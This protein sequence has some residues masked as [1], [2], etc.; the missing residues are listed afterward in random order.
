MGT[1]A[2]APQRCL[3][4]SEVGSAERADRDAFAKQLDAQVA[5]SG[6]QNPIVRKALGQVYLEKREFA[7]AIDQLKQAAE[8]QPNDAETQQALVAAYDGAGDGRGAALQ[9]LSWIELTRRDV[10]LYKDLA[11]RFQKLE[12]PDDAERAITG[13]VEALPLESEGHAMLAEVR[14]QQDRWSEAADEWQQVARIRSL[15]PT[16]YL[17]LAA[18]QVHLKRLDEAAA[19]I[20]TLQ[21]KDWPAH[22]GD[23]RPEVLKLEQQIRRSRARASDK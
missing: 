8:V 9:L 1:D 5:E 11:E 12:Q 13:A 21:S 18:A 15:E 17:R 10:K 22:F 7:K 6:L 20:R 2:S 3:G 23:V 19:T 4:E 14:Q 16:G